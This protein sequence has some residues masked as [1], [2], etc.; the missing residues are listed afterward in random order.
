MRTQR[1]AQRHVHPLETRTI[2]HRARTRFDVTRRTDADADD[3]LGVGVFE[4]LLDRR[5][6]HVGHGGKGEILEIDLVLTVDRPV[7][8]DDRR[9]H[10]RAAQIDA[11]CRTQNEPP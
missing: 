9:G 7:L 3:V 2:E 4:R 8:A 1:L 10:V 5:I 11:D 6:E